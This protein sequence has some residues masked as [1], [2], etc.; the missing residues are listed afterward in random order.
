M[1]VR[2]VREAEP[3][4]DL[5]GA[6]EGEVLGSSLNTTAS[7]TF[8]AAADYLI[9]VPKNRD[10]MSAPQVELGSTPS[11]YIP[12]SGSTATRAAETLTV[13]SA[14]LPWPTVNVIGEELVTNGGF[15]TDSDW[16]KGTGWTISG[17]SANAN[18]ASG[19]HDI[20]QAIDVVEGTL[21]RVE[22]EITAYTSGG[23]TP[24]L[25][26]SG[27]SEADIPLTG[28]FVTSI[29][30][31][32]G[33]GVYYGYVVCPVGQAKVILLRAAGSFIGSID[34]ISVKEI[35]PLAVSIAM[36]GTMT[37]ADDDTSERVLSWEANASNQI[38]YFLNRASTATG[39]VRFW[40]KEEGTTDYVTGALDDYSPG[41]NVPF[42]IASRHGS[43]FVNG[44]VD[45]VALT[46]D[47]TPVA[48]PDLS[49]TDLDLAIGFMGTIRTFRI[50]VEDI[51]DTGIAEASS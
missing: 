45:G 37:Y 49:A 29:S 19:F 4:F 24:Y 40:Q 48:L 9:V 1:T 23:V 25:G 26:N 10:Q 8:T 31:A 33:L 51:G 43:T 14:N 17:G 21:Y 22:F 34:N 12:T 35:D 20:D 6:Y 46:E 30:T 28:P 5:F 32:T 18:I 2:V 7:L 11:S 3:Q 39:Q 47:T 36:E 42:S 15:D 38:I 13:A 27:S 16:T 41:V 50:W 44:A